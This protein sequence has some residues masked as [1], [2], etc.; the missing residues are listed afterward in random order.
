MG[1]CPKPVILPENL[2]FLEEFPAW[3]KFGTADYTQME[4]RKLDA[5]VAIEAE[6]AKQTLR[7]RN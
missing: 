4:A 5:F 6:I 7:Q 3:H 1:C 2:A